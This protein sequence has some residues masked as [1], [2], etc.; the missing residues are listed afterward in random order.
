MGFKLNELIVSCA[1]D[2]DYPPAPI[3][4]TGNS[5]ADRISFTQGDD[6]VTMDLSM[7]YDVVTLLKSKRL[8]D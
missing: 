4:V 1:S 7:L 6:C 8:I 5:I 2:D 3:V